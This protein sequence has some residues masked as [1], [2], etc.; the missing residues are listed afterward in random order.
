MNSAAGSGVSARGKRPSNFRRRWA[1]E[2][3]VKP[4]ELLGLIQPRHCPTHQPNSSHPFCPVANRL[5]DWRRADQQGVENGAH[6][7]VEKNVWE[8]L[9]ASCLDLFPGS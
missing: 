2:A 1:A 7:W 5:I 9:G 4:F 3:T 6:R 8:N